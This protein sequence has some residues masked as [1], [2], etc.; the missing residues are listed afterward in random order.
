MRQ[1]VLRLA[2][3]C[4][5]FPLALVF[6]GQGTPNP[7]NTP[8]LSRETKALSRTLAR[9]SVSGG[10]HRCFGARARRRAD[11]L[12]HGPRRR[13]TASHTAL[14]RAEHR[15]FL[16]Q[17]YCSGAGGGPAGPGL[18]ARGSRAAQGRRGG[19]AEAQRKASC[20]PVVQS[21]ARTVLKH[22][23]RDRKHASPDCRQRLPSPGRTMDA[24]APDE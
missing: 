9:P 21:A 16:R 5:G 12:P 2:S 22:P 10:P 17:A 15:R 3:A 1:R 18:R 20:G 11:A 4:A 23:A 6:P 19:P 7:R 13:H 8:K 24:R 14:K